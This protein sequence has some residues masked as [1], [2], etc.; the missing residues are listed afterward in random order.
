MLEFVG[1]SIVHRQR[2]VKSTYFIKNK[3]I[4]RQLYSGKLLHT[5]RKITFQQK[6]FVGE[7]GK[8]LK[9]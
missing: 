4:K 2:M 7:S 3:F 8:E 5:G 9:K 6:K 1:N